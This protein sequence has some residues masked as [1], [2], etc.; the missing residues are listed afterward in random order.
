MVYKYVTGNVV[1][2]FI[3]IKSITHGWLQDV[4]GWFMYYISYKYEKYLAPWKH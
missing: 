1:P 3:I 4:L 2:N